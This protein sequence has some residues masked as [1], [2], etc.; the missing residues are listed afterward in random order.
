M[1]T[2]GTAGVDAGIYDWRLLKLSAAERL[3]LC[4]MQ[5]RCVTHLGCIKQ[6][7]SFERHW[8]W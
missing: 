1:L 8:E 3:K 2:T 4:L 7:Q 5:P 6:L